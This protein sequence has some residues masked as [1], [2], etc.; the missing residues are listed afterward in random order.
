MRKFITTL[1][2]SALTFGGVFGIASLAN[3]DPHQPAENTVRLKVV[4]LSQP[5]TSPIIT[6]DTSDD[7][8]LVAPLPAAA[9]QI[10]LGPGAVLNDIALKSTAPYVFD[11]DAL[12][13]A[14]EYVDTNY[15]SWT[16]QNTSI[17][18]NTLATIA[19]SKSSDATKV[20]LTATAVATEKNR[21]ADESAMASLDAYKYMSQSDVGIL[22]PSVAALVGSEQDDDYRDFMNRLNSMN[23]IQKAT[24]SMSLQAIDDSNAA[25][26]SL[27][28]SNTAAT[29]A[30]TQKTLAEEKEASSLLAAQT[31]QTLA[32]Q[33]EGEWTNLLKGINKNNYVS[34]SIASSVEAPSPATT[35]PV[36]TVI[37]KWN[38]QLQALR[39]EGIVPPLLASLTYETD[40]LA[41]G[42]TPVYDTQGQV[43]IG[44]ALSPQG[45]LILASESIARVNYALNSLLVPYSE[46][47]TD[48]TLSCQAFVSQAVLSDSTLDL[49]TLYQSAAQYDNV[50][51]I[52]PG[53]I[54]FLGDENIGVHQAGISI[55]GGF[56]IVSSASTGYVSIERLGYDT[57]LSIRPGVSSPETTPAPLRSEG[58]A[59]WNCGGIVNDSAAETAMLS[60]LKPF[61]DTDEITTPY[62]H[63]DAVRFA[64]WA[65]KSFGIGYTAPNDQTPVRSAT[66]GLVIESHLD[67]TLEE[68]VRIKYSELLTVTY[69]GMSTRTVTEGNVL[70]AGD[71]IGLAGV[72]GV[73][74]TGQTP[75]VMIQVNAKDAPIDPTTL[76]NPTKESFSEYPNGQ[77]PTS[78][79]CQV[80][81]GGH[82]LRCDAARAFSALSAAYAAAFGKD[83]SLTD[84][85]RSYEGQL[86]C[87]AAKGDL[88]ATPGTSNHGWGLAID[89]G[90][91]INTFGTPEHEWMRTNAASFGWYHPDWAQ[92]NGSKPEAWHWEYMA[93]Q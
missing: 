25:D 63:E 11:T 29:E 3:S 46:T 93:T 59:N 35:L 67:E 19:R 58:T 28:V 50:T 42:F 65:N 26:E 75:G 45:N 41:Q 83:I 30:N 86:A 2:I 38:Q 78:V 34:V 37:T 68:T 71:F 33:A 16:D 53:D 9:N 61:S 73:Q 39:D 62:G 22:G 43:R 82:L 91:G 6:P 55:G 72:T 74:M 89:F 87:T 52:Y 69:S 18:D 24:Q 44:M 10:H 14:T 27:L 15:Q 1:T 79:L 40:I 85:Y 70:R 5:T 8:A 31:S 56:M 76:L 64:P 84:S 66:T 17:Q 77:I 54:V 4:D 51:D 90:D 21:R 47:A 12:S 57:L 32:V 88:C 23:A 20:Y 81:S 92:A 49:P 48:G 80:G 13:S 60:W 7:S 36:N